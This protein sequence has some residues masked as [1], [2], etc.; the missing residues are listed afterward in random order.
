[1][2]APMEQGQAGDSRNV[3][4][5]LA[6]IAPFIGLAAGGIVLGHLGLSAVRKGRANNRGVALAGTIVSWVFTVLGL[7]GIVLSIF[8]PVF[9]NQQAKADDA[10]VKMSLLDV[11]MEVWNQYGAT[12]EI[13]EVTF[14]GEDFSVAGTLI[15]V[16]SSIHDGRLVVLGA[17]AFCIEADYGFDQ[18]LSVNDSSQFGEGC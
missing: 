4:G 14:D 13:P 5:I 11:E 8:L 6:L 17:S 9:L 3:L 10:A 1:M 12:G 15:P 2:P 18:V 7:A 16:D